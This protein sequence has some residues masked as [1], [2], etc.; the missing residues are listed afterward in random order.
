[1]V[2]W[3][4]IDLPKRRS[5]KGLGSPK[6]LQEDNV[7]III[8]IGVARKVL[9][10]RAIERRVS[11]A[12]RCRRAVTD[13]SLAAPE[14]YAALGHQYRSG[15]AADSDCENCRVRRRQCDKRHVMEEVRSSQ[16]T[17][18]CGVRHRAPHAMAFTF[19]CT[20]K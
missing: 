13:T 1:M 8:I 10:V 14:R 18:H 5:P 17:T 9:H 20:T 6:E 12:R 16:T 2:D 4:P 3:K 19:L 11:L 15:A 7:I